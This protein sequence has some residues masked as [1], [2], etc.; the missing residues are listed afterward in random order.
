MIHFASPYDLGW[1]SAL[2]YSRRCR[3]VAAF[4]DA[5]LNPED[6]TAEPWSDAFYVGWLKATIEV[7]SNRLE[8]DRDLAEM[9]A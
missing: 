3:L 1:N 6:D 7:F 4:H 2:E 8:L 9:E 5:G